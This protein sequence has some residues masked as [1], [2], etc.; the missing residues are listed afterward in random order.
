MV[1]DELQAYC[2][3]N[4]DDSDWFLMYEVGAV[5]LN[6]QPACD[7]VLIGSVAKMLAQEA[8]VAG[9]VH[10]VSHLPPAQP[11]KYFC[12]RAIT[13]TNYLGY[14]GISSYSCSSEHTQFS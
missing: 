8:Q 7:R 3:Q 9:R 13:N 4:P 1:E 14:I 6:L 12:D 2:K 11:R 5:G 10:C